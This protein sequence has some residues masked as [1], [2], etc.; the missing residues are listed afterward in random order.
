MVVQSLRAHRRSCIVAVAVFLLPVVFVAPAGAIRIRV[1]QESRPGAGDFH[2]HILGNIQVMMSK[3]GVDHAYAYNEWDRYSFNGTRPVLRADVSHLFFIET[4]EGLTLFIVHDA[5]DNPDGGSA[6]V[7]VQIVGNRAHAR[8]LLQDDSVSQSD[9]YNVAANGSDFYAWHDWYACCTD[10]LVLGPLAGPW[11]VYMQFIGDEAASDTSFVDGLSR[12]E[13]LSDKGWI[14][15]EL[16]KGRRVLLE[17]TGS[18]VLKR[19][20]DEQELRVRIPR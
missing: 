12:W 18:F 16:E 1:S 11:Q 10:G 20:L 2:Q 9:S 13:A 19:P 3:E 4:R 6:A 17:P 14:P 8:L 7:R 15:L 5:V